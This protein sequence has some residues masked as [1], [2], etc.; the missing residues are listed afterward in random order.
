METAQL[1]AILTVLVAWA[2]AFYT[3]RRWGPGRARRAVRCPE[4]KARAR[5][6]VEQR[7][8]EF[9]RLAVTDVTACSLLDGPVTCDKACLARF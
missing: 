6:V 3:I 4:K 9:G 1:V 5:V 2:V 7:E 8:S